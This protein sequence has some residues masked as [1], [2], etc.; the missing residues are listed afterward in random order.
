M[1]EA[2]GLRRDEEVALY[3]GIVLLGGMFALFLLQLPEVMAGGREFSP[4]LY[5]PG[6]LAFFVAAWKKADSLAWLSVAWLSTY[7]MIDVFFG[8]SFFG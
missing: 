6:I 4:W 1:V 5:V 7:F 2:V 3:V 8:V